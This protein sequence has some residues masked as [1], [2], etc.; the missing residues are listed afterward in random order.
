MRVSAT[1][2]KSPSPR[3]AAVLAGVKQAASVG[4]LLAQSDFVTLHV[5]LVE[6]TRGLLDERRIALMRDGATLLNF[7]RDGM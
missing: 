5:P 6:A 2:L 7:S 3:L 1:T 4:D